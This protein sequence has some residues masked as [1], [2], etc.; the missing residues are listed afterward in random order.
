MQQANPKPQLH[1]SP[2]SLRIFNLADPLRSH[3]NKA[4]AV[5]FPNTKHDVKYINSTGLSFLVLATSAVSLRT[6]L[7]IN[8]LQRLSSS[9]RQIASTLCNALENLISN[10]MQSNT[11]HYLQ[12]NFAPVADECPPLSCINV[13]GP[14]PD[15]LDGLYVR[16]GPNEQYKSTAPTHW[17]HPFDGDGMLHCVSFHGGQVT[18]CC[19]YVHTS[20]FVQEKSAGQALFPKVFSSLTAAKSFVA[21][22][23][24]SLAILRHLLGLIDLTKGIGLANTGLVFHH[25]KLLALGEDDLPYALCIQ[26]N[27]DLVNLGRYTFAGAGNYYINAMTSHPKLDK[28]SGEM[29]FL[30][31]NIFFQPHLTFFRMSPNG[32]LSKRVPI[33]LQEPCMIHDFALTPHFIIFPET[34]LV[35]HPLHLIQGKSPIKCDAQKV[36]RFGVLPRNAT[37]DS[38]LRWFDVPGC[39]CFHILNSWEEHMQPPENI[40]ISKDSLHPQ[41]LAEEIVLILPRGSSPDDLIS[42]RFDKVENTL[43]EV[44]LNLAKGKA[45]QST[46]LGAKGNQTNKMNVEMF[47]MNENYKG[48][49]NRYV[50]MGVLGSSSY[51][52]SGLVKVDLKTRKVVACRMFDEDCYASEPMFVPAA[53]DASINSKEAQEDEG[54][55]LCFLHHENLQQGSTGANDTCKMLVLD[56]K[57]ATLDIIAS[58]KIPRRIPYGF[59]GLFIPRNTISFT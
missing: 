49:K 31:Y 33:S 22:A 59:H 25:G 3:G 12:G 10:N 37:D 23:F 50:Y 57:S 35:F 21:T 48:V 7:A 18:Y 28:E 32:T 20:R 38:E 30:S 53:H 26:A 6:N 51:S 19:R 56:A 40:E 36:Q 55:L 2:S 24:A 9:S 39:N 44:R 16:N 45:A 17:S 47:T 54:C 43:T 46:L 8:A 11:L 4:S 34:Q 41:E 15:F 14:L 58:V 52:L 1:S 13:D 42:G 29:I 27:G 5:E